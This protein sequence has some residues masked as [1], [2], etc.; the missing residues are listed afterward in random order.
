MKDAF[1][2]VLEIGDDVIVVCYSSS[3]SGVKKV[4][5]EQGIITKFSEQYIFVR[6]KE[7][8]GLRKSPQYVAKFFNIKLKESE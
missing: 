7:K 3:A 8:D 1:G 2:N 5:L 6:T 4:W